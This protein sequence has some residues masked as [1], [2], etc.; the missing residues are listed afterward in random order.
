LSRIDLWLGN[1][2][3]GNLQCAFKRGVAAP[4]GVSKAVHDKIQADVVQALSDPEMRERFASFSYE[5][6][7]TTRD[8]FQ[9]FMRS[10][11]ERYAAIIKKTGAQ[12]E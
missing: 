7:P 12:L 9:Q 2:R 6:F 11:S 8:Q 10:E 1:S 5:P 3:R 4:K